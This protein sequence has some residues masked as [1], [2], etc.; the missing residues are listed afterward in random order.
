[1]IAELLTVPQ[2]RPI[3][4]ADLPLFPVE[5]VT[6]FRKTGTQCGFCG[7]EARGL[8]RQNQ[9]VYCTRENCR[10]GWRKQG[11]LPNQG[12]RQPANEVLSLHWLRLNG[13]RP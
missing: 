4:V 5:A 12:Q 6:G 10:G 9:G 3:I 7:Q 11:P 8:D 2:S 13:Y 1:M